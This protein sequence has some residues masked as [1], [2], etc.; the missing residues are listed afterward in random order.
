MPQEDHEANSDA[1][2]SDRH[3]GGFPAVVLVTG[4]FGASWF[5]FDNPFQGFFI[6]FGLGMAIFILFEYLQKQRT[7]D[8]GPPHRPASGP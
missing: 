7:G 1:R 6:L 5:L 3:S 2:P 8:A 4:S